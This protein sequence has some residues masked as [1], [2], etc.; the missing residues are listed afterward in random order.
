[1]TEREKL[2]IL[3]DVLEMDESEI[4]RSLV[5]DDCETWDSVAVLSVI[6][7]INGQFNRFPSAA[8]IRQY[9]T[10]GDLMDAMKQ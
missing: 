1:M 10:V 2:A 3:A 6:A 9:K 4:H 5:L 8:E 7:I